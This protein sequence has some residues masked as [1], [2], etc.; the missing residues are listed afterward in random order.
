[1]NKKIDE[2]NLALEKYF[3][4][5]SILN[6]AKDVLDK[7]N[8]FNKL[9]TYYKFIKNAKKED[10]FFRI[11]C[12]KSMLV[13]DGLIEKKHSDHFGKVEVIDLGDF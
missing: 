13:K 8:N 6:E 12:V 7:A 11:D 3:K 5:D 1:M 4:E 10:A 9:D 2:L